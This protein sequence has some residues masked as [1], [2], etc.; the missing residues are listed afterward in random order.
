M[1]WVGAL[2][3]SLRIV[4]G[5]PYC[6]RIICWKASVRSEPGACTIAGDV[7]QELQHRISCSGQCSRRQDLLVATLAASPAST[8]SAIAEFGM[9]DV[10]SSCPI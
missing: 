1:D 4:V 3:F 7:R 5:T 8:S 2:A 6:V 9:T 10:L